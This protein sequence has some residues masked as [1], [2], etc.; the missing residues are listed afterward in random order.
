M[1]AAGLGD[2]RKGKSLLVSIDNF[3]AL[4]V[5]TTGLSP[6][7]DKIIE[8]GLVRV[9]QGKVREQ[10]SSLIQ[11]GRLIS[12]R[13][14][15][16][17]GITNKMLID[18]PSMEEILPKALAFIG[19]DIIVGHNVNFDIGFMR[20]ACQTVM[21]CAFT[22]DFVDTMRL[23]RAY[24]RD[25]PNHR[26]STLVSAFCIEQVEAHRALADA[27]ATARCYLHMCKHV[28]ERKDQV[29]KV[30]MEGIRF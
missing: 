26:L 27:L 21:Q 12:S 22:N 17:T 18:A 5:E 4:D 30:G 15:S 9:R 23:G 7:T 8:I 13:I 1:S 29:T 25:L 14:A 3:V 11:P 2:N 28:A 16:L 24:F 20:A 10:Y 19:D 6:Q